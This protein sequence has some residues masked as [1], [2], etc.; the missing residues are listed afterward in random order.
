MMIALCSMLTIKYPNWVSIGQ[1]I[2]T[3]LAYVL[4]VFICVFLVG[5]TIL[6]VVESK[7]HAIKQMKKAKEPVC[8]E[9]VQAS[10]LRLIKSRNKC[11]P[12]ATGSS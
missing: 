11:K 2:D 10:G 1:K 7:R 8:S 12:K 4:L 6:M 9:A 3:V 5:S